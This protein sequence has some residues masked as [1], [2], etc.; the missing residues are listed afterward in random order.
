MS[1]KIKQI[2]AKY[3]RRPYSS[4]IEFEEEVLAAVAELEQQITNKEFARKEAIRDRQKTELKL[5]EI[6]NHLR[7]LLKFYEGDP[8]GDCEY[9]V[10]IVKNLKEL[11]DGGEQK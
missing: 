4:T 9:Q 5:S 11:L 3:R 1:E 6:R 10:D 2:F 8:W 7:F